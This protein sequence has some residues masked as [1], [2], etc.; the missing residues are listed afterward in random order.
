MIIR[1]PWTVGQLISNI[2]CSGDQTIVPLREPC[3]NFYRY[4]E[5]FWWVLSSEALRS[6]LYKLPM[7][8]QTKCHF[9]SQPILFF[10]LVKDLNPCPS[11]CKGGR[12]NIN[13]RISVGSNL[14]HYRSAPG[15]PSQVR[16]A[17]QMLHAYHIIPCITFT[18][19]F[20]FTFHIVYIYTFILHTHT[21][22]KINMY[23]YIY[24]PSV[25]PHNTCTLDPSQM[26]VQ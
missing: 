25:D 2:C 17:M 26:P 14:N 23:V 3:S 6:M 8:S 13:F 11:C 12:R 10:V 21:D 20:R 4:D 1:M 9:Q 7:E 16:A 19:S 18:F 15:F 24:I 22:N 5:F